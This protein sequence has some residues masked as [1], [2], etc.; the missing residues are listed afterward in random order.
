MPTEL[1]LRRSPSRLPG[2]VRRR[3]FTLIE[4]LITVAIL[5]ILVAVVGPSFTEA[6]LSN[7]LASYSNNFVASAN[8]ARSEAIK[9]NS[10][11]RMCRSGDGA[12]CATSGGWQQ[13][14]IVFHDANNNS[15]VDA[16][17]AVI[18]VQNALSPDY[19]FTGDSYNI[20]FRAIG[21]GSTS[22]TLALCR[23]TPSP[24]GQERA[25][26]VSLTGR[27]SVSTTRTGVC[28]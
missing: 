1:Q 10:S 25:L 3:G 21:A 7:R 22:A 26:T 16:G 2:G 15:A 24:G 8:L 23:A 5:A 12:T 19:R 9:R 14:W 17:E 28:A 4:L 18:Q 6:I 27:T 13:G 11:V 20:V